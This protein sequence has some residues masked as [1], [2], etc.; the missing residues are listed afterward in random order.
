LYWG[1]LDEEIDMFIEK[2]AQ[3][4]VIKVSVISQYMNRLLHRSLYGIAVFRM[5]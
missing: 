4:K 1:I 3:D 5:D 2:I